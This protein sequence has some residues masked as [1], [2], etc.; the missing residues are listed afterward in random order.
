MYASVRSAVA[1]FALVLVAKMAVLL[2][3]MPAQ[4]WSA[5]QLLLGESSI[6][7]P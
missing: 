4:Q 6:P 5:A 2:D 1:K 7:V 3:G